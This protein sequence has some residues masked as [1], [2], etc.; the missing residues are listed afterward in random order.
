MAESVTRDEFEA[1]E[2]REMPGI[3]DGA[4]REVLREPHG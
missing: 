2:G 1:P 3:V 4:M